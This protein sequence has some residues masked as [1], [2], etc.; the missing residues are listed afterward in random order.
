MFSPRFLFVPDI[1]VGHILRCPTDHSYSNP[2]L[3]SASDTGCSSTLLPTDR[4]YLDLRMFRTDSR[5]HT[6]ASCPSLK[7]SY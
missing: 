3:R 1:N 4:S 6:Q 5:L 7:T 2:V